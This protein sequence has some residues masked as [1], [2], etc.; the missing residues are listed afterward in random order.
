MSDDVEISCGTSLLFAMGQGHLTDH[1][2]WSGHL[3][4]FN[5]PAMARPLLVRDIR[6]LLNHDLLTHIEAATNER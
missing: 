4:I 3:W 1:F 2:R 6:F 5:T